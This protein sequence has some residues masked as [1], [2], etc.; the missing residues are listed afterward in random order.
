MEPEWSD[1]RVGD[2]PLDR[3]YFELCTTVGYNIGSFKN[4]DAVKIFTGPSIS[5]AIKYL[6]R[7]RADRTIF[8]EPSE[9]GDY[10]FDYLRCEKSSN[11][12]SSWTASISVEIKHWG[13]ML[14]YDKN[15]SSEKCIRGLTIDDSIDSVHLLTRYFF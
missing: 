2:I 9:R 10:A 1:A 4:V 6:E 7:L 14:R 13:L 8:L 5:Y 15:L 11:L 12:S 3:S